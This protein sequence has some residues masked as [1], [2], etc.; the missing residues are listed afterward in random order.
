MGA[1]LQDWY[2]L[3]PPLWSQIL[4][5][6]VAVLCGL[7]V[8]A[9]RERK[10]KPAGLR[11]MALV[12]LGSA[13]FTMLSLA[14]PGEHGDRAR[15]AAQIVVGIG[16]LGAGTILRGPAGVTGLTTAAT[17]WAVAAAGTLVGAG[18]GAA[19]LALSLLIVSIL[20]GVSR[21]EARYLGPCR[22]VTTEIVFDP[23][24]GKTALRIDNLLG[25]S[26][27]S[28]DPPQIERLRD[29]LARSVIRVCMAHRLHRE[30]LLEIA[31]LPAVREIHEEGETR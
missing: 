3:I 4:L 11:T 13:V 28:L 26:H 6:L 24:G 9:E 18:Y 27:G 10:D 8:G 14:I 29:G 30:F 5:V 12:S 1:L 17:I 2:V 22:Y 19:G 31:E 15:I 7:V 16:F 23:D 25:G 20:I 21:I